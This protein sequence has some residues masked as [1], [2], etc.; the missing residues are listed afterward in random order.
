MDIAYRD[1]RELSGV[2]AGFRAPLQQ[3]IL[4]HAFY[5]FTYFVSLKF[6]I[7]LGTAYNFFK[8]IANFVYAYLYFLLKQVVNY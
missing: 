7:F 1:K 2:C 4:L 3:K 5:S 6:H 8:M